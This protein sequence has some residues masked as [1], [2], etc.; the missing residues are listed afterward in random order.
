MESMM[1]SKLFQLKITLQ[2][3]H[4]KVWRKFVVPA[5][6]KLNQLHDAVQTVMGWQQCH[7]HEF[8]LGGERYGMPDPD[9]FDDDDEVLPEKQYRLDK[10]VCE[11][12]GRFKYVYDFGDNWEHI[13]SIE[14]FDYQDDS[15]RILFCLKGSGS[16]PPE[17]VGSTP[18]Y[19]DFCT[20]INDTAHPDHDSMKEWVYGFCGYPKTMTWPDG[21]DI[22]CVNK[23]LAVN[24]AKLKLATAPKKKPAA[25]NKKK[26]VYMWLPPKE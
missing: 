19:E 20:A 7:L 26:P 16:C 10:L 22:D 14:S 24:E 9:G 25:A 11:G 18:G 17:D 1:N 5:D 4:V 21:F 23:R 13:I 2:H 12:H 3:C 6:I 8:E 15:G